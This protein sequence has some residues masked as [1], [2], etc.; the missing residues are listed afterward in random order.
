[1]LP[2]GASRLVGNLRSGASAADSSRS[3]SKSANAGSCSA[4]HVAAWATTAGRARTEQATTRAPRPQDVLL[5]RAHV[6]LVT[7]ARVRAWATTPGRVEGVQ[8]SPGVAP[9]PHP[10]HAHLVSGVA[11]VVPHPHHVHQ[12]LGVAP[13]PHPQHAH[14]VPG[15]AHVVPHPQHVHQV[16]GVAPVPHP[17]HPQRSR[18]PA[19]QDSTKTLPPSTAAWT[20]TKAKWTYCGLPTT[21][22][23]T[24][25][26]T[27]MTAMRTYRHS[28]RQHH[29][30]DSDTAR[31]GAAVPGMVRP[32][33]TVREFTCAAAG[34]ESWG[35]TRGLAPGKVAQVDQHVRV[36]PEVSRVPP[37]VSH[38]NPPWARPR[39]RA[40]A[41]G[42]ALRN[43]C[44]PTRTRGV[45][46][47]MPP[48]QTTARTISQTARVVP[49]A[50]VVPGSARRR[51][52]DRLYNADAT[53]GGSGWGVEIKREKLCMQVHTNRFASPFGK[54]TVSSGDARR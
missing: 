48:T 11:H 42:N 7:A 28:L 14:L 22:V 53:Q 1:M 19:P 34:A 10:Q 18:Q 26:G 44:G 8:A 49:S 36:M 33:C 47:R 32:A 45:R 35:T 5:S 46:R 21:T 52:R 2:A 30:G 6:H 24:T 13:A 9:A 23:M 25:T 31:A 29:V 43:A 12:V 27:V 20:A 3:P 16:L 37:H 51:P 39:R 41:R 4:V 40:N 17:Q 50:Y 15:V 38:P 54:R